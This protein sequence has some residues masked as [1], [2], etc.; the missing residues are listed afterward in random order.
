MS[1]RKWSVEEDEEAD[2]YVLAPDGHRFYF[3]NIEGTSKC[4]FDNARFIVEAC[5]HYAGE[6]DRMFNTVVDNTDTG[7]MKWV[8]IH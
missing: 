1:N 4:C 8:L 3:G 5:N 7:R 6:L 2:W